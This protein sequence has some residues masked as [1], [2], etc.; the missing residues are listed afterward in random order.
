MGMNEARQGYSTALDLIE[1]FAAIPKRKA[2]EYAQMIPSAEKI[3]DCG[4]PDLQQ[5]AERVIA[6][7]I[8]KQHARKWWKF[9]QR[10]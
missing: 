5:R 8:K 10:L 9:W 6:E 1:G 7:L 3:L 4:F 2:E